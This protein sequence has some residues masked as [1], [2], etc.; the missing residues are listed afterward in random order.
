MKGMNRS[1][2]VLVASALCVLL[3]APMTSAQWSGTATDFTYFNGGDL[4][5]KFGTPTV[6]GNSLSFPF[7]NFQASSSGTLAIDT[8]TLSFDFDIT[9]PLLEISQV[10]VFA[11]G[12]YSIQNLGTVD[13]Q[14]SLVVS[15]RPG[16]VFLSSFSASAA[17]PVSG[18]TGGSVMWSGLNALDIGAVIPSPIPNLHLDLSSTLVADAP[19]GG[20]AVITQQFEAI[21]IVFTFIPEP[22]TAGLLALGGLLLVRRR[23]RR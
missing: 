9:T 11:I 7:T 14:N 15:E 20:S 8:D 5:G 1:G 16:R 6:A 10:R 4:N 13:V 12:N 18:P 19:S 22:A 3:C 23:R 17:F 21:E 2:L